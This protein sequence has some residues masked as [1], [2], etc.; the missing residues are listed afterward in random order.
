MPNI[1]V[2][3]NSITRTYLEV[4]DDTHAERAAAAQDEPQQIE[5]VQTSV[6]TVH[7]RLKLLIAHVHRSDTCRRTRNITSLKPCVCTVCVSH[8]A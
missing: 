7:E 1:H 6:V 2:G 8:L 5:A 4:C 3:L